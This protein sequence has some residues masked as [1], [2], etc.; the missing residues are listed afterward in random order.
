MLAVAEL[1]ARIGRVPVLRGVNLTI[2]EGET[3]NVLPQI[4][5]PR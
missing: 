2:G 1:T 4:D 3:H 5:T